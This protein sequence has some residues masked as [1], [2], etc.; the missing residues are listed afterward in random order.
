MRRA[1]AVRRAGMWDGTATCS[2]TLAFADRHR[3][4]FRLADDAGEAFLLDLSQATVLADGDALELDDGGLMRVNAAQEA[5]LDIE[6]DT[7]EQAL[8]IAWHIGN[9]HTRVQVMAGGRLRI[10]A[11]PVLEAMV[12][13]LGGRIHSARAPFSPEAGAYAHGAAA[14]GHD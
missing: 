10:L 13:G 7:P 3:R 14:H 1:I 5:V 8:R 2:V 11:D 9:R 6:P 4:R 12:A